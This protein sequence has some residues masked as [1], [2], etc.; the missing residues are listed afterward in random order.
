MCTQTEPAAP[1]ST[2]QALAMLRAGLGYL[3]ACDAAELG[4]AG[5]AEALVGLGQ[6]GAQHTAARARILAALT[7]QHGY[8]APGGAGRFTP[9]AWGPG[10]RSPGG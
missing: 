10:R 1:S 3:S 7:A 4:T 5:L 9:R 2:A 6:A 8:Q